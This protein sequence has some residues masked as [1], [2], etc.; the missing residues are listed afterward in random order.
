[1]AKHQ[2]IGKMKKVLVIKGKK[3]EEYIETDFD[4]NYSNIVVNCGNYLVS[5]KHKTG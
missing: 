1:M 2:V 4:I 3:G 5:I